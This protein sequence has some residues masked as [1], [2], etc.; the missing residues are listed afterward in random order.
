MEVTGVTRTGV[1]NFIDLLVGILRGFC[2]SCVGFGVQRFRL[3]SRR[4]R[5]CRVIVQSSRA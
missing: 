1:I 5:G 4:F 2:N 3:R